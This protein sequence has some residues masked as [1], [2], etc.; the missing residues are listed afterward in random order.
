MEEDSLLDRSLAGEEEAFTELM[1][2]NQV[3]VFRHCLSVVRDEEIAQDLTQETFLQAYRHL[4][5]F[6]RKAKFSTWLWKIAHNLSL[7]YL[8]KHNHLQELP[9]K[10]EIVAST[11]PPPEEDREKIDSIRAE[12]STLD[13]KHRIVFEL[14]HFNRLSQKEI[15]AQLQIPPGTVRSRL[16]YAKKKLQNK[17]NRPDLF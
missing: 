14:Y 4:G 6:K 16:H 9:L 13:E 12:L 2:Q 11:P 3:A 1:S 17:L 15:A 8:K 10:E 7:A 5:D